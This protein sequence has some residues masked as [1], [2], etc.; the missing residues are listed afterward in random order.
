MFTRRRLTARTAPVPLQVGHGD[1]ITVPL[2]PQ[3]EHGTE[4]ENMPWPCDST[5]RPSQRGQTVGLVPGRAPV[6]EQVEQRSDSGIVERHLRAVDGL[7]E[8]DLDLR[9]EV[10]P[11][12]GPAGAPRAPGAAHRRRRRRTG[13]RG[14]R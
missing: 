7:V 13:S 5:P 8:A 1:S 14:C 11:A 4:I 2:P 3:R 9:L 6:P 12:L 10:A